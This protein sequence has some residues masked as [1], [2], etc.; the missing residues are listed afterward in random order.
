MV[1][2]A[3]QTPAMSLVTTSRG[4]NINVHDYGPPDGPTCVAIH[5]FGD[6]AYVWNPLARALKG[7]RLLAI[8]LRGHGNSGWDKAANYGL[9][10]HLSDIDALISTFALERFVVVGHSLGG[11]IA[12]NTA[13]RHPSRVVA[14]GT[15]D[16]G[17]AMS[18]IGQ[19][20]A[21]ADF[22]ASFRPFANC[23]E[24]E[25]WLLSARPITST[26]FLPHIS[27]HSLKKQDNH[28]INKCDPKLAQHANNADGDV[29]LPTILPHLRCPVLVL[30]GQASAV[31]PARSAQLTANHLRYGE[32]RSISG[33]G[34]AVVTENP[35][36]LASK[37]A[38]YFVTNLSRTKWSM[39]SGSAR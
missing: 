37:L 23:Q 21:L 25:D 28:F 11:R 35:D 36:E 27:A 24:Y 13:A 14:V 4:L 5:G 18:T 29:N 32:S 8:D 3:H 15:V 39:C 12:L 31:F 10:A 33:A 26:A 38:E 30:R 7:W 19:E 2:M 17:L 9:S 34:H 16:F 1:K 22:L 20:Q 6:G